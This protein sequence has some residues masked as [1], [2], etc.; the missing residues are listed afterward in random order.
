METPA[1]QLMDLLFDLYQRLSSSGG[2][3]GAMN[4]IES[5]NHFSNS[6]S[7]GRK[8]TYA[9]KSQGL[10]FQKDYEYIKDKISEIATIISKLEG[11]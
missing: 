1:N 8:C 6:S 2:K 11:K 3:K 9:L 5:Y 10:F 7:A 4:V